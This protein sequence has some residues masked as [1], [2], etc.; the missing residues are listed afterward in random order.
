MEKDIDLILDA[1]EQAGVELPVARELKTLLRGAVEAGY[2]DLD[3]MALFLYL[4]SASLD[5]EVVR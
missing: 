5:Q 4:R 3:F 1:A 2:A